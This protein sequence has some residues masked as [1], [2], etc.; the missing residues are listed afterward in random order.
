MEVGKGSI[1]DLLK[2]NNQYIVPVY[3]RKYGWDIKTQCARLWNDIV[4]MERKKKKQHFIGSIVNV[5]E[6]IAPMKVNKYLIIDGQQRVTT[7]TL[8]MIALRDS[9]KADPEMLAE[10]E[11]IN[12]YYLKNIGKKGDDMYKLVLTDHDEDV[13][14]A[15]VDNLPIDENEQSNVFLNYRYFCECIASGVLSANELSEAMTKLRIV[16][17][18]LEEDDDPQSIFESLNSTGKDLEQSDL[19][20]NHIL[21]QLDRDE[22]EEIYFKY[23]RPMEDAF[24]EKYRSRLLDNFFRDYLTMKNSS[25]PNQGKVYEAFKD[26][27]ANTDFDDKKELCSDLVKYSKCYVGIAYNL[28]ADKELKEAFYSI[29]S[30][31][32]VVAYPFLL[33][34]FGDYKAGIITKEELLSIIRMTESYVVRRAVCDLSTNS[35]NKT[36]ASLGREIC[37]EDYLNSVKAAFVL[38]QDYKE[39][40]TDE[41][42]KRNLLERDVYKMR[43]SKYILIK[44]E[45]YDNKEANIFDDKFTIEH[46]MPQNISHSV[47]WQEALGTE[48]WEEQ[49][50]EYVHKLG[51]LTLTKYNSEM[52]NKSF[53]DKLPEYKKAVAHRLNYYVTQ[54]STWNIEKIKERTRLL[55]EIA[56]KVWTHPQIDDASLE[57]YKQADETSPHRFTFETY[58]IT[59]ANILSIYHAFD[60]AVLAL[61]PSI[62]REYK[63]LYIAYKYKRNVVDIVPQKSRLRLSINMKFD[64]IDDP[65]GICRDVTNL[66]RWGNGD[67]EIHY[68]NVNQLPAIMK[69]VKQSLEKQKGLSSQTDLFQ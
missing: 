38:M 65:L 33:Q 63:K 59:D 50:D 35:L 20:R 69:I 48:D 19:I 42:F 4:D 55:A 36:F 25:I 64:E 68:T 23:W 3:Q 12:N 39:Y 27:E 53:N 30:I 49:H 14:K 6:Q 2:D 56:L 46:I 28:E 1:Y 8:L 44:L 24:P 34:V 61:E 22:Q 10:V 60:E 13:L 41:E 47:S 15:L 21:M 57:N 37:Q 31:K 11:T 40:P 18:T 5:T 26:F 9:M 32:M 62:K 17:I 7:L 29:S 16:N 54:Q 67:A 45:N 58:E 43:N 66:G 51:N 52:S